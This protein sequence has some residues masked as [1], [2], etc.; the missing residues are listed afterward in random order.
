MM[1]DFRDNGTFDP[2][3]AIVYVAFNAYLYTDFR[4]IRPNPTFRSFCPQNGKS[5]VSTVLEQ[6]VSMSPKTIKVAIS[7]FM[8]RK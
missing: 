5:C 3:A 7:R 2:V 6:N 1:Y 8:L 4:G